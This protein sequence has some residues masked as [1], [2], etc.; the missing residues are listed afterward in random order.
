M[1]FPIHGEAEVLTVAARLRQDLDLLLR[2]AIPQWQSCRL[3]LTRLEGGM[4]NENYCVRVEN[5]TPFF[6]RVGGQDA[7][8]L[9]IDRDH[10]HLA[11]QTAASLGVAP[12]VRFYVRCH[13]L[14]VT[15][16][17]HGRSLNPEDFRSGD[18]LQQAVRLLR[19]IHGVTPPIKSFSVFQTIRDYWSLV[20]TRDE[21]LGRLF[22]QG[23]EMAGVVEQAMPQLPLGLCHNDLLAANF[24]LESR[25]DRL[26]L[27][28]WEYAGVGS[29]Y[30][31]LGNFASNQELLPDG[32]VT[33]THL[34]FGSRDVRR[35]VAAIRL[36][37]VMS[38]M[39]EALWGFV[40][41]VISPL[42]MD[43]ETYGRRHW[44][45]VQAALDDGLIFRELQALGSV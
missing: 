27:V 35:H 22:G 33:L 28:D 7:A 12:L 18:H 36:M 45:R 11:T 16:F 41:H 30:F 9:G 14:L 37:R 17:V 31:D 25:T 23:L 24:V 21:S 32:E 26:W 4:T 15:D 1:V 44:N 34:Y 8:Q 10:E 20:K 29:P 2:A 19:K 39:R 40:Q 42:E 5:E 6:V 13:R 43:F 3:D 38:D